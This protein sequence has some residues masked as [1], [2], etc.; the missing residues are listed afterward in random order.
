MARD[1]GRLVADGLSTAPPGS[2]DPGR[3]CS[4]PTRCSPSSLYVRSTDIFP[5]SI[6]YPANLPEYGVRVVSSMFLKEK[7]ISTYFDGLKGLIFPLILTGAYLSTAPV[8]DTSA[9]AEGSEESP[10]NGT[11]HILNAVA[12]FGVRERSAKF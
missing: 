1:T 10:V 5:F 12:K 2:V 4:P 9:R 8:I 6:A 7:A 11:V 3:V